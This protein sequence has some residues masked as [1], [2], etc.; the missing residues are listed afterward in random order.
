MNVEHDLWVGKSLLSRKGLKGNGR[1][2]EASG[3]WG[4]WSWWWGV[5]RIERDGRIFEENP[6]PRDVHGG[7]VGRQLVGGGCR[8][9]A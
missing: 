8:N 2:P 6:T 4:G 5:G 7:T 1:A 3:M 9:E